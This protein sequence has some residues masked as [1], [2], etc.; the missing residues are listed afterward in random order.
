[1]QHAQAAGKWKNRTEPRGKYSSSPIVGRN[2]YIHTDL[3][4][5]K[6]CENESEALKKAPKKKRRKRKKKKKKTTRQF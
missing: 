3:Y 5:A 4:S 2:T 1:M 6:N